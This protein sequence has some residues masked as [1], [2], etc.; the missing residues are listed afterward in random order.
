MYN[1]KNYVVHSAMGNHAIIEL[2]T[3]GSS[4]YYGPFNKAYLN[5]I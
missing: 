2:K 5:G 3:K 1:G 4:I